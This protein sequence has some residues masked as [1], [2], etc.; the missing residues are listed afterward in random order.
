LIS[1]F[2]LQFSKVSRIWFYFLFGSTF[3]AIAG[4]FPL[5]KP[6]RALLMVAFPP[7]FG[8]LIRIVSTRTVPP[9][10]VSPGRGRFFSLYFVLVVES[11]TSW[12]IRRNLRIFFFAFGFSISE[13]NHLSS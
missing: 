3:A 13:I 5:T 1:A 9:G 2:S 6:G 11:W 7:V 4:R 8:N 10:L 12:F